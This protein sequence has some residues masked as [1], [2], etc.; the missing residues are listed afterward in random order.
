MKTFIIKLNA[1]L[2]IAAIT[3]VSCGE[4]ETNKAAENP[5]PETDSVV[6]AVTITEA[7]FKNAGIKLGYMETKKL[8]ET[9]KASGYIEVPPQNFA[10]VS[11]YIGGVVKSVQVQEG[12]FVKK[13]QTVITLEHP[14]FIKLQQEYIAGKNNFLFLEKEY[15][16]QKE[17][18]EH[19]AASGKI[20]QETESK[21]KT[22]KGNVASLENQLS[23]LSISTDDLDKG[24]I[25]RTIALK[26]PIEGYISHLNISLGAYAE[27][28]KELFDVTDIGHL[29]VHL[30][31][32]EK[33]IIKVHNGQKIYIS[34]PNQST[35]EIEGEIF[36]MGKSVDN[37]T[38]TISVRAEIKDN[39]KHNLIPG[40]FVNASISIADNDSKSIPV[41][42][43][44][45]TGQ[46][47][48][49]FMAT[50][51]WCT[52]P[53]ATIKAARE[54]VPKTEMSRDSISLSYKMVEVKTTASANG[55]VGIIPLE[56]I[57]NSNIVVVKGAYFLMS[58]L[59]S[60][61]TVGC[62]GEGEEAKK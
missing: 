57:S 12:D 42:A 10:E 48:Y 18:F 16:R 22:E 21:Y 33:D 27:P 35:Q 51:E 25:I 45:R 17:L 13:G 41:D 47:Q 59:K 1:L 15:Q 52:N 7:Q 26:A 58:Q 28:N 49:V 31:I 39:Q 3:L 4:K 38:K 37:E 20:F 36:T 14:D 62:C 53:N 46:K 60:G 2:F 30:K 50:D 61:E 5:K 44:I 43:V 56:E 24:Q 19:N 32:F 40:M 9:I 8:P 55:Y 54:T 6:T 23:M 34:L 29:I 11:T